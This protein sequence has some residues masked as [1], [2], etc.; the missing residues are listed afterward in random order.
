LKLKYD[1]LLSS[2]GLKFKLRRYN[3]E[4]LASAVAQAADAEAERSA[5]Q[6]QAAAAV[7]VWRCRLSR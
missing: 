6:A 3:K 1:I 4:K 7:E 5:A 2:I